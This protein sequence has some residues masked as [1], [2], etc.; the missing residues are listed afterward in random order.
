MCIKHGQI[1]T[2]SFYL[3]PDA[4]PD[5][6]GIPDVPS[7]PFRTPIIGSEPQEMESLSKVYTF[8]ISV[9]LWTEMDLNHRRLALQASALPLSYQSVEKGGI[10]KQIAS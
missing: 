2:V 8:L 9:D 10:S 7:N 1:F 6:A 5:R 3:T 4:G